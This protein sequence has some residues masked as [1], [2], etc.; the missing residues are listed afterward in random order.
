MKRILWIPRSLVLALFVA[1][2]GGTVA[3]PVFGEIEG[4]KANVEA[5]AEAEWRARLD[6]LSEQL[7]AARKRA[8][9]ATY[10][11]Q[12]WRQRKWPRG[13]KKADMLAEIEESEAQLAELEAEWP[14]T[15]EKARRAGAPQELLRRYEL[16]AANREG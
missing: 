2:L 11:Y 14:E 12:N 13:A 1:C 16:P 5:E 10:A 7:L 9:D 3:T 4:A 15:L 6:E 8:A